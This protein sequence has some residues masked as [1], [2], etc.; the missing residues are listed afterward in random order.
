MTSCPVYSW[1]CVIRSLVLNEVISRLLFFLLAIVC[2]TSKYGFWLSL[3]HLQTLIILNYKVIC[4]VVYMSMLC[5]SWITIRSFLH[6]WPIAGF[7]TRVTLRVSLAELIRGT[8]A[9]SKL[10][11]GNVLLCVLFNIS[12]FVL[13]S[14]LFWPLCC[15]S[16]LDL[17]FVISPWCFRRGFVG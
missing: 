8:W 4:F 16:F 14:C 7:V 2:P 1:M 15:L 9:H 3:W 13:L 6:S 11:V 12:F 10:L 17:W 5:L